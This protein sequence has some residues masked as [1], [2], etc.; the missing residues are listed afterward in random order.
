MPWYLQSS[1]CMEGIRTL[2]KILKMLL[3]HRVGNAGAADTA[4][5][6]EGLACLCD[7]SP[8]SLTHL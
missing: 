5:G 6:E 3:P 2:G 8:A 1:L 4:P 7:L